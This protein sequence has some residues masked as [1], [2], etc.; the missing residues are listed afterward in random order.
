MSNLTE[1]LPDTENA[2]L[3]FLIEPSRAVFFLVHPIACGCGRLSNLIIHRDGTGRCACCDEE[4]L[5]KAAN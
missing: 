5:A 2:I 4:Y 3:Q 1:C